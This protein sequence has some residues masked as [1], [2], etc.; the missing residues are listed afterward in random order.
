MSEQ[1]AATKAGPW[2]GYPCSNKATVLDGTT[3]HCG[4]HSDAAVAKRKVTRVAWREQD[5]V[6]W[7]AEAA[8]R[9]EAEVKQA[10]I[11]RRAGCYEPMLAA[12]EAA[13]LVLERRHP[14]PVNQANAANDAKRW[15][16]EAAA[17][18][19]Q[20]QAAIADARPGHAEQAR[21][22]DAWCNGCEGVHTI[23]E[24]R[25]LNCDCDQ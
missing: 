16:S 25:S 11:E 10:E 6:R 5:S 23:A 18:Q 2:G 8:S 7:K 9:R 19:T 15:E 14:N 21:D 13:K 20:V 17:A 24:C 3:W 4:T 22:L 1:C 12:L